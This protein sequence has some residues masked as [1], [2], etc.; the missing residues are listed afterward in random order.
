MGPVR[1]AGVEVDRQV[2]GHHP[3]RLPRGVGHQA[4]QLP[5]GPVEGRCRR[6]GCLGELES[7][8]GVGG[9]GSGELLAGRND[10]SE[11]RA[12]LRATRTVR[13]RPDAAGS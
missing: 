13:R 8:L 12:D 2:L 6:E 4:Q 5:E 7:N 1:E 9:V 10:D 11:G 3:A